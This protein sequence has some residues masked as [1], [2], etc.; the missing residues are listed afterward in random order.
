[1]HTILVIVIGLCVLIACLVAGRLMT[2]AR[3]GA[4]Y[5]LP[6]WLIGAAL[7]LWIG[8]TRAG[9]AFSAELPIFVIVFGIPAVA[10][11]VAWRQLR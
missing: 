6:I 11:L 4:L 9:Y 8:V 1:M 7:N 10:A 5:F 3:M 2:S